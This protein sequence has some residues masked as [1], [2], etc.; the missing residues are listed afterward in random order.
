MACPRCQG[1]DAGITARRRPTPLLL[2]S[3][4]SGP[5]SRMS[6]RLRTPAYWLTCSGSHGWSVRIR[7]RVEAV[8]TLGSLATPRH[9][10]QQPT[11]VSRNA[12][13]QFRSHTAADPA[14]SSES[15][16]LECGR[17]PD[18]AGP[19]RCYDRARPELVAVRAGRGEIGLGHRRRTS[20][21]KPINRREE[22]RGLPGMGRR[23]TF[24]RL[25]TKNNADPAAQEY[26][27]RRSVKTTD[28]ETINE[29][30]H[31]REIPL[32]RNLRCPKPYMC[33]GALSHQ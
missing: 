33:T 27:L 30:K 25:P 1:H 28:G 22:A 5:P 16:C 7:I 32:D 3:P 14:R 31:R 9:S 12:R 8:S 17:E 19:M 29:K 10:V 2:R 21:R 20:P 4:R 11:T 26:T 23:E 24:P 15:W 6:R 18:A 13:P